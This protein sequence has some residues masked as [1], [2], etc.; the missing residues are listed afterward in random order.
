MSGFNAFNLVPPSHGSPLALFLFTGI[1]VVLFLLLLLLIVLLARNILK[2]Y[3]DGRSRV[4]GS[5]LR[6]R[7]LLGA[8]LLS[9]APIVFMA[10]FSFLLMNRSL[11]RWFSQP[12]SHLRDQSLQLALQLAHYVSGNAR[13]EAES[14]ARA[15]G[16]LKGYDTADRDE[17]ATEM[18]RHRITLEG[19]FVLVYRDGVAVASYQVPTAVAHAA[20]HTWPDVALSSADNATGS[21]PTPT[22]GRALPARRALQSAHPGSAEPAAAKFDLSTLSPAQQAFSSMAL[23]GAESPDG[24]ILSLE[25]ADAFALGAASFDDGGVIVVALPLPTGLGA[26]V[27]NIAAG[28]QEYWAVYRQR[29]AVRSTFLLLLTLVT[30]LTFF[31]SSWLALF[32]S[33]QITRPVEALADAMDAIADGDYRQRIDSR[34]TE[35]LSELI[36][37]F[38]QMA[39]DLEESR[40]IADSSAARIEEANRN[41]KARQHELELILETIPSGVVV[42]D[43]ERSVLQVNRAFLDLLTASLPAGATLLAREPDQPVPAGIRLEDLLPAAILDEV[44]RLERRAQ[45]MGVAGVELEL[46]ASSAAAHGG[47]SNLKAGEALSLSVTIAVLNLGRDQTGQQRRGSIVVVDDVSDVLQAQR[48]V[49]WKEVAQ[50]VAHEIK[51]PLTPIALSAERI[52]RHIDRKQPESWTIIRKCSEVI[53]SSVESMRLLVD[54]FGSLAEFPVAQPCAASLNEIAENALLLFHGRL[55]GIEI[56]TKFAPALP[57]VM[58]DA[59]ALKRALANL[60]DN[61]AEAMNGSFHR[62]LRIET[63]LSERTGMA[64]LIVADTGPGLSREVRERLFLPYF[65]TKQRGTGLGLSIAAKIV[66]DHHGNIRA[67]QRGSAGACFVIE[68]PLARVAEPEAENI[69]A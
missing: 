37:S 50:R 40:M 19:G 46:P 68:L 8:L 1:T 41:L 64:E 34:A 20:L 54:Q 48:Q 36:A 6:S 29:R 52:Q 57:L 14:I 55:D 39:T 18:R 31:A 10:L 49:A 28:A 15:P 17:L 21:S 13:A 65:S 61:A 30:T 11:D 12:V 4:L 56:Q 51:N 9:F 42:L 43:G 69:P 62:M 47:P 60:I 26:T 27:D 67:E 2:M 66:Q 53:L 22:V 3:G 58:A 32:L 44:L 5:R 7:M 25:E 59:E 45:R 23:R 33:K 35:E 16:F 38:N 63:S 24:P